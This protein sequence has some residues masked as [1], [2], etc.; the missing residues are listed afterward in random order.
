[1]LLIGL[2]KVFGIYSERN[3]KL[4]ESFEQSDMPL[5]FYN[6]IALL[7]TENTPKKCQAETFRIFSVTSN[8]IPN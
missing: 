3:W 8:K 5:T 6:R 1:M 7:A 2:N 4:L